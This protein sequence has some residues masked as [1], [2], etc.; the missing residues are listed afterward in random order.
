M[1]TRFVVGAVAVL[2]AAL[3][4][5]AD[6]DAQIT[7][8]LKG[9]A[10]FSDLSN[11]ADEWQTARET[12]FVGGAYAL[13]GFEVRIALATRPE[14]RAGDDALWDRAET[15][16]RAA[17]E[18]TGHAFEVLE[19]DG[20]FYGPK[21]DFRVRDALRREHQLGTVQL[22]YNLPERFDLK[23]VDT[24]DRERR[25]AMIHRAMLGS[26]ERFLG[27]LIEHCGGGFPVWLAPE[28]VRVLSI[29]ERTA[30]R[31]REISRRLREA[32]F[33]AEADDRNEKVGAKIREAQLAKVPFML[34]IGDREAEAGTVA[35]RTRLGGDEGA[36]PLEAFTA[37]LAEES[38]PA[39]SSL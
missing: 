4:A 24:E 18:S 34:V 38:V 33:R 22:D 13:F 7:L 26:L 8:G 21:I 36:V 27:I 3:M 20:A 2:M 14:D 17:L 30:E 16:L 15:E 19:G 39:P 37:R 31:A 35:V 9:G 25:P 12:S 29:T 10:N 5:P 23:Y 6:V 28:Q 1:K 11:V 32:G